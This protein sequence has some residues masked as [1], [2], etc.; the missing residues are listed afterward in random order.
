M[1]MLCRYFCG[2]WMFQNITY[3]NGKKTFIFLSKHSCRRNFEKYELCGQVCC[4]VVA[5]LNWYRMSRFQ[6]FYRATK[7]RN[8]HYGK[9]TLSTYISTR[10]PLV[11]F[12][13][14]QN[15]NSPF[16]CRGQKAIGK[17]Y[18]Y[19]GLSQTF[20]IQGIRNLMDKG[21]TKFRATQ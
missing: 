9:F 6:R 2:M 14:V 7:V 1:M 21:C 15:V 18:S 10:F 20:N 17:S 8:F 3:I 19:V 5:K 4:K 11:I 12:E 13:T 16:V